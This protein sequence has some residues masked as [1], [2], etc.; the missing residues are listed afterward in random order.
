MKL[1]LLLSSALV[2]AA[3]P[4][5]ASATDISTF[6]ATLTSSSPTELGRPVRSGT[7]QTWFNAET[8]S[9]KNNTGT[10]FSYMTYTFAASLFTGAPYVEI[11]IYDSLSGSSDFLSAYGGSFNVN[12]QATNWLGD[13]GSSGNL[14]FFAN[15]PGEARYFDVTLTPGQNL[16]LVLNSTG[17]AGLNDP[18]FINVSAYA[19]TMYDDPTSGTT[20]PPTATTPEPSTFITLGT[21]LIGIAGAARRRLR[22]A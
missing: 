19:D 7:Q 3:L 15:D 17:S 1:T 8:Y 14:R 13:Q 11:S 20:P 16:V 9:G 10:T 4:T 18:Q 5:I 12:S 21:G 22:R 6:T 2:L